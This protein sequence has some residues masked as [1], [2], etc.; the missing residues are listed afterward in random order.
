MR[1]RYYHGNTEYL[2]LYKYHGVALIYQLTLTYSHFSPFLTNHFSV[3]VSA[4]NVA[5]SSGGGDNTM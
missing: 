3:D 4:V 2:S 5:C 1:H